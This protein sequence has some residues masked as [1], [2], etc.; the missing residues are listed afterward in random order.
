MVRATTGRAEPADCPPGA[1]PLVTVSPT[2]LGARRLWRAEGRVVDIEEVRLRMAAGQAQHADEGAA[3]D[4][5]GIAYQIAV[6]LSGQR[7]PA[8][9]RGRRLEALGDLVGH[10]GA[11]QRGPQ[12]PREVVLGQ[13]ALVGAGR[14]RR[15]RGGRQFRVA[16]AL[17]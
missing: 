6:Y 4:R 13:L 9:G 10:A 14:Q 3:A 12:G 1:S 2:T 16:A 5:A 7:H 8:A 17:T 11:R 15:L